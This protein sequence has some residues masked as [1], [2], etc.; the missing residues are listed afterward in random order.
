MEKKAGRPPPGEDRRKKKRRRSPSP[1]KL[2]ETLAIPVAFDREHSLPFELLPRDPNAWLDRIG[3]QDTERGG[4]AVLGP[5]AVVEFR[6]IL[7]TYLTFLQREKFA[8]LRKLRESQANLPIAAYREEILNQAR[9]EH[10]P[11]PLNILIN[12]VCPSWLVLK[13][14]LCAL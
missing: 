12:P 7:A 9:P 2:S 10:S 4:S 14:Y 8:R 3:F 11:V 5:P 13:P 1:P 6:Q